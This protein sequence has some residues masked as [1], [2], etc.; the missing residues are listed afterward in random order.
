MID[1]DE[2]VTNL[3]ITVAYREKYSKNVSVSLRMNLKL[4]EAIIK[5]I[6]RGRY[7]IFSRTQFISKRAFNQLG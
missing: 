3:K 4:L 5:F 7:Q 6:Y 1:I 2:N